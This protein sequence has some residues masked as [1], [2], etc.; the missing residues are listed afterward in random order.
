M[1]GMP[2]RM[3]LRGGTYYCRVWVPTDV[4]PTF[5]RTLVVTSLRTKDLK[6][7]KSRLARKTVELEDQFERVRSERDTANHVSGSQRTEGDFFA[8]AKRYGAE[9][10]EREIVAQATFF[11][12]ATRDPKGLWSGDLIILPTA[13]DYGHGEADA[14]THFDRLVAEGNL[15]AVIAYLQRF[16]VRRRVKDLTNMRA[17]GNLAEFSTTADRLCPGLG[18]SQRLVFARLLLTEELRTLQSLQ[19][20]KVH[21]VRFSV[22]QGEPD[23]GSRPSSPA[24]S[25]STASKSESVSLN[26]LFQ[27]WEKESD[28][29]A[30]TLSSWRGIVRNLTAHLGHKADD[31]RSIESGEI[32]DW[33]DALVKSGKAAK[34]ISN[35]HLG[36]ARALFRF[37]VANKLMDADPA[38]GVRVS[39]KLKP[40]T[41]MLA[42]ENDEVARLLKLASAA[43]EPWKRW[44][45]WLSAATGSRIGEM[46]QLHGSHVF[47]RD[48]ISVLKIA[49]ATDGGSIKNAESER[50]VPIHSKL[51]QDGFLSFVKDR[52]D[53]PLFYKR[54]SGD[55][56]R[57]HASKGLS[58]R[59]AAWIR[60]NGF[61]DLRKAPNHALRHWFK[62]ETARLG[63]L[64][65]VADAIQ[66]HSDGRASSGYRHIALQVMS[67]AIEQ[68]ELPPR[69]IKT[70]PSRF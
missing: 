63:I 14:F 42:Y 50:L 59:L 34:T 38:E 12:Q 20:E 66:G 2:E 27:R 49:P 3:M 52:G 61:T 53:G 60:D 41:K 57:K 16:R 30:S 35:G 65:S 36:C 24:L 9:V 55:P 64:D 25:H 37:A 47:E 48:G 33:K 40:G 21:A 62:S 46:A 29:S 70:S 51:I 54:T 19:D 1:A 7:A 68:I 43:S 6:I 58:N 31:I 13:A 44:L 56:K 69:P 26:E 8:L 28:P 23:W 11:E 18:E 22:A 45:P 4:A 15:D 67:D 5:G 10:S 39:R 32:V 17:T